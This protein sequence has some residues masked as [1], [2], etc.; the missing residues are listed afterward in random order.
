MPVMKKSQTAA[1][2]PTAA[3][4]VL[5]EQALRAMPEQ[6]YMNDAQLEFFRQR[7]LEMRQEILSRESATRDR[8]NQSESHADPADRATAEEESFL[9]LRL[10]EREARLLQKIDES[11]ASIRRKD[12]GYCTETGEPIG[13]PRLLVRPTATVCVDVKDRN[14]RLAQS[15]AS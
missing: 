3:S 10:R 15:Q 8:L 14:E 11:L 9:D 5:T 13:I 1:K 12:Y 2:I 7:L 4:H 6:D